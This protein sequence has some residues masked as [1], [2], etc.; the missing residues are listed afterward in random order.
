MYDLWYNRGVIELLREAYARH[1]VYMVDIWGAG[2]PGLWANKAVSEVADL[3]GLKIRAIGATAK[4]L[5]KLGA[6]TTYVPHDE[7]YTAL[8]L[9]TI[10]GYSTSPFAYRDFKHY[11]I[12]KYVMVPQIGRVGIGILIAN[13]DAWAELD[14][15]LQAVVHLAMGRLFIENGTAE[16]EQSDI[17]LFNE[18]PGLGGEIVTFSPE[19]QQA[20]T[21]ATVEYLYEYAAEFP[22][23][24]VGGMVDLIVEYMKL[25]GYL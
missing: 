22:E 13:P 15:D 10:D 18:V 24:N 17:M 7:S 19:L 23:S 11:E 14:E 1:D 20:L 2:G 4:L 8:Q 25:Q 5:D 3:Q 21:E 16:L 12:A 6:S 9:G